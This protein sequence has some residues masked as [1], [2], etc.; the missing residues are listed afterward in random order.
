MIYVKD[1]CVTD[2][3]AARFFLHV[4]PT[5]PED[6]SDARKEYGFD[7]M[8]FGFSLYG[9]VT[10]GRCIAVRDLPEY[11][12]RSIS[13]GQFDEG[14][15]EIWRIEIRPAESAPPLSEH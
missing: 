7:N 13:T 1:P 5:D 11:D 2:D 8:D 6:L 12:I 9:V 15:G 14:E 10:D 3:F 4:T